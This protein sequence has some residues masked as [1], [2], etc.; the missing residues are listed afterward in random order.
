MDNIEKK[1]IEFMHE[2]NENMNVTYSNQVAAELLNIINLHHNGVVFKG[3]T[4]S[5]KDKLHYNMAKYYVKAF[6]VY[7]AIK[8]SKKHNIVHEIEYVKDVNLPYLLEPL[9]E[10][11][12][13][14]NYA[15]HLKQI[16][17]SYINLDRI[18]EKLIK[19]T[20]LPSLEEMDEIVLETK[21]NIQQIIYPKKLFNTFELFSEKRQL[22]ELKKL[23]SNL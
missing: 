8:K 19:N 9:S 2:S 4:Y 21:K 22:T 5:N 6:Q 14:Y 15:F 23:F 18:L 3:N 12:I 17:E 20:F 11:H 16:H 10:L 7:Y 1:L 13:A